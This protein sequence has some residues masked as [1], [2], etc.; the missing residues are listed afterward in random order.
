MSSGSNNSRNR[1]THTTRAPARA[2]IPSETIVLRGRVTRD[3]WGYRSPSGI[4]RTHGVIRSRVER[5][6]YVAWNCFVYCK[7]V[8]TASS[9]DTKPLPISR[10][11]VPVTGRHQRP[12]SKQS[13]R[14]NGIFISTASG[15]CWPTPK[16]QGQ[17]CQPRQT[18][19]P[20][21]YS[22]PTTVDRQRP[23]AVSAQKGKAAT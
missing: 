13:G 11:P 4:R 19:S 1:A 20:N 18:A 21:L 8:Q 6:T 10:F 9:V 17:R 15:S 7:S 16:V 12:I 3:A 14:L 5:S 22:R 2:P 23:Q